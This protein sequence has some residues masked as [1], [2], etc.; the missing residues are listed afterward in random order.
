MKTETEQQIWNE[1]SRLISNAIIYYNT[2]LLSVVYEQ[3]Q[4]AGDE[5]A[6]AALASISPV[7]WQHVNLI[8]A[9]EFSPAR[10]INLAEMAAR[11]ADPACWRKAFEGEEEEIAFA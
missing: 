1:C 5:E 6:M 7:A 8:G 11:Y 10:T 9:I 3:K 2:A 4:A